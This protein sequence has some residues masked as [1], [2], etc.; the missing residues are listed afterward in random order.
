MEKPVRI[1]I[2]DHE[3][4]LRSD[5][6]ES[7]VQKIAQFVNHRLDEI[8]SRAEN[9]TESK[10]AILAAFYIASDYFQLR[11]ERDEAVKKFDDRVRSLNFQI[12]SVTQKID[13]EEVD[14]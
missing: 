11:K 2:L 14:S 4:L 8:R 1:R 12:D 3:Y 7:F 5:E 13:F 9:L 6:D 10:A